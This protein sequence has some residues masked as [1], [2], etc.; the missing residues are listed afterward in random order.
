VRIVV[1]HQL[2]ARSRELERVAPATAH[3][4]EVA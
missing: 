2:A 1:D 3:V 4:Q